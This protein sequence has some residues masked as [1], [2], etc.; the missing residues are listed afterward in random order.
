[1]DEVVGDPVD[2]PGNAYRIDET[3]NY[4]GPKRHARK[5]IKHPE[6]VSAV[7]K[8]G[9]DWDR[10]PARMRKD[11]GVRPRAFDTYEVA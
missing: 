8:G 9:R 1:M 2:V 3:E 4:H 7:N 6:E 5:K 10:V 11:P